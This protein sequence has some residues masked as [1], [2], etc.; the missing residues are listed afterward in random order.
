MV[1]RA[2]WSRTLGGATRSSSLEIAVAD[3]ARAGDLAE[4]I[5]A[6]ARRRLPG[7]RL[8]ASSTASCSRRSR[9]QQL[10]LF[11]LL[12]LIV[13][14]STFNVASTLV[15]LVRERL[16]DIGVL[17]ALGLSPEQL[18][19]VFLLYGGALGLAGVAARR[20]ARRAA[21]PGSPTASS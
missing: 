16:R 10:A 13:L 7:H 19:G 12:G 1:A 8:A 18:R 21:S 6:S 4:E 9:L 5:R 2:S 11:L 17:A 14:V 20:R 3:P 15:V